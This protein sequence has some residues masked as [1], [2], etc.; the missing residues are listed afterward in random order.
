M[1]PLSELTF[2]FRK[3]DTKQ[4]GYIKEQELLVLM[5][6]IMPSF[7]VADFQK[8]ICRETFYNNGNVKYEDFIYWL[9]LP[10]AGLIIS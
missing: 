9:A 7:P 1:S 10:E 5:R 8:A 3:C 6:K 2:A 4:D